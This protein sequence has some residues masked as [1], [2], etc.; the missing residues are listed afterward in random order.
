MPCLAKL[1]YATSA[2][3]FSQ[4]V[5]I[6]P[7]YLAQKTTSV[8]ARGGKDGRQWHEKMTTSSWTEVYGMLKKRRWDANDVSKESLVWSAEEGCYICS[9]IWRIYSSF[10]NKGSGYR[11]SVEKI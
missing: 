10:I 7:L 6:V 9:I 3:P 5:Q 4:G 11:L 8:P 2:K 1:T